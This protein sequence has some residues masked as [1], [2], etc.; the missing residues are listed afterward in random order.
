MK[1]EIALL[2]DEEMNAIVGG[3][4]EFR[5]RKNDGIGLRLLALFFP[6]LSR[7]IGRGSPVALG[8]GHLGL[9]D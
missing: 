2:K 8:G 7:I 9:V 3:Y 6:I 1:T 5:T 4:L